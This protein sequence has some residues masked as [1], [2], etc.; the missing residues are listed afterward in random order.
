MRFFYCHSCK[1]VETVSRYVEV[2]MHRHEMQLIMMKRFETKRDLNQ[3]R[4][5]VKANERDRRKLETSGTDAG[6]SK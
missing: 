3:F 5:E 2:L 6:V 4:K 1:V